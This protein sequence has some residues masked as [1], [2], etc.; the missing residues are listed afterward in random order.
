LVRILAYFC[1]RTT[2]FTCRAGCKERGFTKNRNAGPVK[3]YVQVY[4]LAGMLA[5]EVLVHDAR[6][7]FQVR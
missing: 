3:L 6:K 4:S 1:S 2:P 7:S 5:K